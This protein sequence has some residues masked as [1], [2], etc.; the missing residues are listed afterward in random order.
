MTRLVKLA[1]WAYAA[2]IPLGICAAL[3]ALACVVSAHNHGTPQPDPLTGH[4]Y[5]MDAQNRFSPEIVV[6]VTKAYHLTYVISE[7]LFMAFMISAVALILGGA[8]LGIGPRKR[9]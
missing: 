5:A 1:I 3:V 9:H 2:F 4:I 7:V 8:L 6:Y